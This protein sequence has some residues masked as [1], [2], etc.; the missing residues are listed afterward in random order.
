MSRPPTVIICVVPGEQ[1]FVSQERMQD[2]QLAYSE[3]LHTM[4]STFPAKSRLL[5][6]S[7][8]GVIGSNII[9]VLIPVIPNVDY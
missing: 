8:N 1:R 5:D 6:T 4:P 2:T 7:K 9:L 3:H